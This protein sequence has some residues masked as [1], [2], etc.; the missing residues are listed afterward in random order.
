MEELRAS[1]VNSVTELAEGAGG[2]GGGAQGQGSGLTAA[3]LTVQA[4]RRID[5]AQVRD[6]G[7]KGS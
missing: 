3:K 4:V 2:G 1:I 7:R 6:H 5:N